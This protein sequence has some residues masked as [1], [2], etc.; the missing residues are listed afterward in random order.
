MRPPRRALLGLGFQTV[1]LVACGGEPAAP[2]PAKT[3]LRGVSYEALRAE[4]H[5]LRAST[6]FAAAP[7]A[8]SLGPDPYDVAAL[9]DGRFVGLERAAGALVLL[10]VNATVLS[11]FTG[12]E[13]PRAL[14][15]LPDGGLLVGGDLGPVA[16]GFRVRDGGIARDAGLDLDTGMTSVRGLA[17]SED[18]C[19]FAVSERD[20]LLFGSCRGVRRALSTP[21][22][23]FQVQVAGGR[24]VVASGIGHALAS[25]PL[26]EDGLPVTELT[27]VV[28]DGPFFGLSA[29]PRGDELLVAAGGV[30]DA[31][32]D[33]TGGFFGNIDSF[34]YLYAVGRGGFRRLG[35]VNTSEIGVVTPKAVELTVNDGNAVMFVTGYASEVAALVQV[36][37]GGEGAPRTEVVPSAPGISRLARAEGGGFVGASPL[38][39]AWATIRPGAPP[40]LA[41]AASAPRDER[42]LGEALVFTTLMAPWQS[43]D[44]P[45]S[46]FTCET[47][48]FEGGVDGRTHRTGRGDVRATTKPLR[49]LFN[50]A[51]HFTRALDAD[52]TE[53]IFAEFGVAAAGSTSDGWFALDEAPMEWTR[54]VAWAADVDRSAVGLRRA[55]LAYFSAAGPQP[56]PRA[57]GRRVFDALE[58]QGADRFAEICASCHAP[59]LVADDPSTAAER[60]DWE[61]LVLSEAAPIV[62]ARDGYEKT[63]VEPYVHPEG[64]RPTSLRRLEDKRPY[65]TNGGARTL[66]EVLERVRLGD[67]GAF[68][69]DGEPAG[70]RPLPADDRSAILAFLRLL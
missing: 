4:E 8:A 3:G 43:A 41:F 16:L 60:G 57:A 55:L 47:C 40:R 46:R 52:T 69:H 1:C 65:F 36:P 19:V 42:A 62:W 15:A 5:A 14:A 49:G 28:H 24:V 13:R 11:R 21:P 51:P 66:E 2:E 31:P 27:S 7:S 70:A 53:M 10:D 45:K 61:R 20:D 67:G 6:D 26:A 23:P 48:H 33:R 59:R 50:N 22:G 12:L 39:D 32:L 37:L 29:A 56:N 63:G 68:F 30:E 38:L 18:G 64:A 54:R 35:A 9:P 58:R 17:V 25:A 44:G 34:V